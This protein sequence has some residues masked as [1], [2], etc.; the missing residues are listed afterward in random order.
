MQR[1][2]GKS[3]AGHIDSNMRH[4]APK[5]NA[6]EIP[7]QPSGEV[8]TGRLR[9]RGCGQRR[10]S[11]TTFPTTAAKCDAGRSVSHM[12]V[13][14]RRGARGRRLTRLILFSW[15]LAWAGLIR[16][17]W[18][19]LAAHVAV[20]VLLYIGRPNGFPR[21]TRIRAEFTANK[22]REFVSSANRRELRGNALGLFPIYAC[23]RIG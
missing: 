6:L 4:S 15:D 17:L 21:R 2:S 9:G 19:T 1:L 22:F 8:T 11:S 16:L 18:V 20:F 13:S 12:N 3:R 10:S 7:S 23:T 14:W 5:S